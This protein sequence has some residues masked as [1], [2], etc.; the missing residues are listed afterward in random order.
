LCA[1]VE[2]EFKIRMKH[3]KRRKPLARPG[4]Q[5]RRKPRTPPGRRKRLLQL[6]RRLLVGLAAVL[7][8][9]IAPVIILR[10]VAP[11]TS[12]VMLQRILV[13]G[14]EVD[15]RWVPLSQISPQAA[16]AVVAAEDQKFPDHWGFD[17][18]A[19]RNAVEHNARGKRLRGASTLTQQVARNL[20]L[21]QGRSYLRKGLEACFTLLLEFFWPKQRILEIY[22]NIAETGPQVFGMEAAARRYFGHSASTLTQ[23]QAALIAT[24]LPNPLRYHADRPSDYI[25]SRRDQILQQMLQ[26]G[27]VSYL[28]DIL[29]SAAERN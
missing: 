21:W 18:K 22:L 11:P 20:F 8:L 16:L 23:E 9:C 1:R 27:G 10:W 3:E 19:I 25:L 24:V 2:A 28:R 17:L 6:R 29:G 5:K 26:L 14:H 15:Y 4:R 13:Q 7:L 12:A